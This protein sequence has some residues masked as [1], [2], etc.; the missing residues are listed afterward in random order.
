[1]RRALLSVACLAIAG[2]FFYG[3]GSS[4]SSG[5][6]GGSS[7]GG[8]A[9]GAN[10]G[11]SGNASGSG[12]ASGGNT[13]GAGNA[14]GAGGSG[15][16]AGTGGGTGGIEDAGIPD[17]TFTYD[18]PVGSDGGVTQD[19]ACAATTAQAEPVALDM[20]IMLDQSGSMA[21][22]CNIGDTTA[23]KWCYAINALNGFFNAPSSVGMGVALQYFPITGYSCST[24]GGTCATPAVPLSILPNNITAFQNSLNAQPASGSNTPTEAGIRGLVDYTG[25]NVQPGRV[26]IGVLITDGAPNGCNS[27]AAYLGGLVQAH[28]NATGIRTFVIGMTGATFS[29]LE[30]IATAG[31][32]QAHTNYCSGAGPCHYYNVGN[33]DPLAF[34][35]ALQAI[36][37]SAIGCQYNVPK[38]EG[39]VVDPDKVNVQ[40]TPGGGGAPQPITKVSDQGQCGPSGGWYYDNNLSPTTINLCASTCTAV[41]SDSQA[42]IDILLGCLGS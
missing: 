26:M 31:G 35:A 36:Q 11:G 33:G 39:G 38:A 23:S 8:G 5:G 24:N 21:P 19:S 28:Y 25:K 13:G 22:D 30:T 14:A 7:A 41:Q 27:G 40:Y 9:A 42:K 18:G 32:A 29:T 12:G 3:C 10:T 4:G 2:S 1:M 20:Y 15:N 16:S 37:Q 6:G 17:V 34:I